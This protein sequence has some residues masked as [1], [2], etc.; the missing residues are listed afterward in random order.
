[1][2]VKI[3]FFS[4]ASKRV[5]VVALILFAAG[6]GSS[7]TAPTCTVTDTIAF[8]STDT[9]VGTG[10]AASVGHTL[11]TNYTGWLYDPTMPNNEGVSFG[12]GTAFSFAL[13]EG[14]VIP[15]WDQGLVGMKVGGTRVLVVPPSLGYG[16]TANGP[17]P[18]NSTLVFQ[19]MLT[20]VI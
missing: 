10:T 4:R 20:N 6:C 12:N 15:G 17:I 18:A 11:T 16:C 3:D 2:N 5:V 9:V 1:M 13:G 8:S 7:T 14:Q 19:I